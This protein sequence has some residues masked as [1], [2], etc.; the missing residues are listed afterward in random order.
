[1]HLIFRLLSRCKSHLLHTKFYWDLHSKKV[2]NES[3][4]MSCL[5]KQRANGMMLIPFFTRGKWYVQSRAQQHQGDSLSI[6]TS[7]LLLF[8]CMP[9]KLIWNMNSNQLTRIAKQRIL[10]SDTML[11]NSTKASESSLAAKVS[12]DLVAMTAPVIWLRTATLIP[13]FCSSVASNTLP[14]NKKLNIIILFLKKKI[15]WQ[16]IQSSILSSLSG[17]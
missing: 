14:S 7:S 2:Q 5:K 16:R 6:F 12:N 9:Y 11:M 4:F 1:M 15:P 10:P 8:Y 13:L 17:T 3:S